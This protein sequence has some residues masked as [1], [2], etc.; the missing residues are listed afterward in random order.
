MRPQPGK[1]RLRTLRP[2]IETID[3]RSAKVPEKVVDPHYLSPEHRRWRSEV[4]RRAGGRCEFPGCGRAEPRMFADHIR[5]LKDGQSTRPGERPVPL[6]CLPFAQDYRGAGT[7]A[8]DAGRHPVRS[9]RQGP[10][11]GLKSGMFPP[12][13]RLGVT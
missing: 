3:T 11:G 9:W 5:E 4:I 10:Q 6:R 1:A 2:R 13:Y 12:S 7:A 8:V